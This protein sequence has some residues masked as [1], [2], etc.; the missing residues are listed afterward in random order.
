MAMKGFPPADL[1][2]SYSAIETVWKPP[3]KICD[4]TDEIRQVAAYV[5]GQGFAPESIANFAGSILMPD[6]LKKDAP[7]AKAVGVR[8]HRRQASAMRYRPPNGRALQR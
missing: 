4:R 7:Q 3:M 2:K 6:D 8:R 1:Y 5:K